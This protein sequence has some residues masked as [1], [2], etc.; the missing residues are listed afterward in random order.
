[1][2]GELWV[3]DSPASLA[4]ISS[5]SSENLEADSVCKIHEEKDFIAFCSS[6]PHN[7]SW[8]DCTR[9]SIFITELITCFQKYS[10]CC[11]L[12]EIFR[13]VQKSFE[14]PQAKAQ[15]PTIERATLTRDFY[16]FPGN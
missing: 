5:Q 15:M 12:M 9:G 1:K 8:R 14:V 16:L 4:V 2:L 7:V 6:T 3:R 11:H 10:C 13:K